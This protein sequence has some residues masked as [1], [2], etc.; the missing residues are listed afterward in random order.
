[1]TT[2]GYYR[3]ALPT[4][5][6]DAQTDCMNASTIAAAEQVGVRVID[7][8]QWTC[9]TQQCVKYVGGNLLRV[10]GLHFDKATEPVA[11]KWILDEVL[12]RWQ[13]PDPG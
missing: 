2:A 5:G 3:G 7:L 11:A 4:E 8:G 13:P 6:A 12:D 9:P 10:D 1:M